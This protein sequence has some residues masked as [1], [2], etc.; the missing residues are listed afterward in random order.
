MTS[1]TGPAVGAEDEG[2]LSDDEVEDVA[3]GIVPVGQE[4]G[5]AFAYRTVEPGT[6]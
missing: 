2:D 4:G 3:G 5:G 6:S 1:D